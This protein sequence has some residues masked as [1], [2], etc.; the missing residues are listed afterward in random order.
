M[1]T[2]LPY[3]SRIFLR[4]GGPVSCLTAPG[5][6]MSDQTRAVYLNNLTP[7]AID[8]M[9]LYYRAY[10]MSLLAEPQQ[11]DYLSDVIDQP[12][13]IL[14]GD[15]DPVMTA[16][17]YRYCRETSPALRHY[18]FPTGQHWVNQEFPDK[19]NQILEQW[20]AECL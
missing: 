5:V 3:W 20:V 11:F 10:L 4:D 15:Q 16:S 14:S 19:T 6:Q 18:A 1:G 17:T 9:S 13:L 7:D 2:A 8:A 12:C